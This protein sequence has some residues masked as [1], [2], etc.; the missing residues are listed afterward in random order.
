MGKVKF[1][2]RLLREA[3]EQGRNVKREKHIG[4][5][6]ALLFLVAFVLGMVLW[7]FLVRYVKPL[8]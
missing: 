8:G 4:L 5:Y 1:R 7:L 3:G 6:L 2:S